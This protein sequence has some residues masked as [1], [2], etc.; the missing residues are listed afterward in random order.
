MGDL[1]RLFRYD[2]WGNST[3]LEF[4]AAQPNAPARGGQLL[5]HVLG[6]QT[7][8]LDRIAAMPHT[9][10]DWPEWSLAEC[11]ER[12]DPLAIRVAA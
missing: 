9:A 3:L 1:P 6:A 2:Q 5:A 7:V 4:M 10:P 12:L 11:G 8:W